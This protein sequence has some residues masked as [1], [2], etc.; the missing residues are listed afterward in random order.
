MNLS[1]QTIQKLLK[2]GKHVLQF[3]ILSPPPLLE[4]IRLAENEEGEGEKRDTP[5]LQRIN[6]KPDD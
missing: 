2:W 5:V 6:L 1:F 3:N 4:K